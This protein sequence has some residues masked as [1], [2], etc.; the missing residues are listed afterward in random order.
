MGEILSMLIVFAFLYVWLGR[1]SREEFI[2]RG[3]HKH[4]APLIIEIIMAP[5]FTVS[6]LFFF[7]GMIGLGAA[8]LIPA[9]IGGLLFLWLILNVL[10]LY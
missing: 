5:I 9:T 7:M 4:N 3:W 8:Y 1:V 10:G 2:S 6:G